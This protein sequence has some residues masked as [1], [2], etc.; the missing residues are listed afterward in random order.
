MV[1]IPIAAVAFALLVLLTA[2]GL[3]IILNPRFRPA[4]QLAGGSLLMGLLAAGVGAHFGRELPAVAAQEKADDASSEPIAESKPALAVTESTEPAATESAES[5]PAEAAPAEAAPAAP[6]PGSVSITPGAASSVAPATE[7]KLDSSEAVPAATKPEDIRIETLAD[8]SI[9]IP[10]GRP[11]WVK[12]AKSDRRGPVHT[13]YVTSHPHV[14]DDDAAEHALDQALTRATN[15]YISDQL[16]SPLA[17]RFI[18]YSTQAIKDRFVK[19]TYSETMNFESVGLMEQKHALLE[20]DE[21]FRN[22]LRQTWA[23][24][25]ADSRLYQVGLGAGAA[26]LLLGSVFS[27]FR[28]DNAT[29][30]YYT[31]RLQFLTAAAILAIVALAS[32]AAFQFTWL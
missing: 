29:R 11:Q 5:S 31:G 10:A 15:E 22:E 20:F 1:I 30:G 4:L 6:A 14:L 13:I 27:Y 24:R 2:I 16:H 7:I 12:N 9:V 32:A 21:G 28:L 19:Q 8:G 3:R 17:A 23:G 26:L 25:I 18:P